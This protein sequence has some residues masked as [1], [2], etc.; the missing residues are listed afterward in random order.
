M[1]SRAAFIFGGV[2]AFIMMLG[3]ELISAYLRRKRLIRL[4]AAEGVKCEGIVTAVGPSTLKV[5]DVT[6]WKVKYSFKDQ[7]GGE[8][9]GETDYI[10]PDEAA[11]WEVGQQG[12]VRYVKSN[13]SQHLWFGRE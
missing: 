9:T 2:G 13:P 12:V 8:H 11:N 10:S 4:L 1:G 7:L 5:N 6:Q 3:V